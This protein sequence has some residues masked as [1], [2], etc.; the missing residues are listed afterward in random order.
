MLV[1]VGMKKESDPN[2]TMY[3]C[4]YNVIMTKNI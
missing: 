4:I 2:I 1:A 3:L